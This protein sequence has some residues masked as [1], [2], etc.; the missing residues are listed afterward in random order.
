LLHELDE[1]IAEDGTVDLVCDPGMEI[2]LELDNRTFTLA[3][4]S[5]ALSVRGASTI[6]SSSF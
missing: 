6:T 3:E 2:P 5:E 4:L 1:V